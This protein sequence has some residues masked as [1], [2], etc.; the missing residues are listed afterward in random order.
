[1]YY[2]LDLSLINLTYLLN[3]TL[4]LQ[5]PTLHSVYQTQPYT[6]FTKPNHTL[7]LPNP[8]PHWVYQTQPYTQFTK[9]NPTLSLPNP[10]LH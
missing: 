5:N 6:Q 2:D 3:L 9:P 1:M 10:T 7:S 4:S 8:T